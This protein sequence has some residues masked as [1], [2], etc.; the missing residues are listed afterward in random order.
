MLPLLKQ[1]HGERLKKPIWRHTVQNIL[2]THSSIS[3]IWLIMPFYECAQLLNFFNC[4]TTI[5]HIYI[6]TYIYVYIY[7]YICPRLRL[8]H[9]SSFK[10]RHS[11]WN[12]WSREQRIQK[13]NKSAWVHGVQ[14]WVMKYGVTSCQKTPTIILDDVARN[15]E[16]FPVWWNEGLTIPILRRVTDPNRSIILEIFYEISGRKM[17]FKTCTKHIDNYETTAILRG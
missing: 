8:H 17:Y 12:N 6:Y 3:F 9:N 14:V 10:T 11:T 16:L 7:I 4:I 2:I 15:L 5:P 13:T 1:Y